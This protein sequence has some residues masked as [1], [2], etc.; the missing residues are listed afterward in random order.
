MQH[1]PAQAQW[2]DPSLPGRGRA[3]VRG[4]ALGRERAARRKLLAACGEPPIEIERWID[5]V[6]SGHPAATPIARAVVKDR[7]AL[8]R[9]LLNPNLFT[10]GDYAAGRIEI[11]GD[12]VGFLTGIYRGLDTLPERSLRA[13]FL[14]FINRPRANTLSGSRQHIHHH[15]DLGNDA[16]RL[17]LGTAAMQYTCA[18][19]E[20][21]TVTIDAAQ[22][23]KLDPVARK[24]ELQPGDVV[25]EAGCGWSG[26]ARHD[27]VT[28]RAFNISEEQV[29]FARARA[30]AEGL[31]E[32]IDHVLD[33]Y[34]NLSGPCDTFV[35]VGMLE[36]VGLANYPVLGDVIDRAL[37]P[38]G[39]G[40]IH[41]IGRNKPQPM[42][43]W[44]EK[45]IFPG[46]YPPSIG[47]TMKIFE[48]HAFSVLDVENLRLHDAETLRRWLA[49][50]TANKDRVL[51]MHD[52]NFVRMWRRYL[53][54]LKAAFLAG[55]LH[56]FQVVFARPHDNPL[57]RGRRHLYPEAA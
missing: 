29:K 35:S 6:F 39:R 37:K 1:S 53:A 7:I 16:H 50:Y 10:G 56:F 49:R 5:E 43:V 4:R 45:R 3:P 21:P 40:L 51:A 9:R 57:P 32:R 26:L 41:S 30:R 19:F 22:I 28:V 17:W 31:A 20:S 46:A 13:R 24:L 8:W 47:E 14:R 38:E 54:G 34:R 55:A 11:S 42:N 44:I 52:Q 33:D 2:P 18:H 48:G 12:L 15:Y 27:G 25:F 23:A 36:H